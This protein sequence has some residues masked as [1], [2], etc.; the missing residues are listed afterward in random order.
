[1]LRAGAEPAAEPEP[2]R[3]EIAAG[4]VEPE[5]PP[6]CAAALRDLRLFRAR[7]ADGLDARV[8]RLLVA[9]AGEV[10]V[11]ELRLAPVALA[12]LVARIANERQADP[13]R[14]AV[15]PQDRAALAH[16]GFPVDV[17]ATL[18]PG[19]AIVIFAE[20]EIDARLGVRLAR[21]LEELR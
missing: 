11:R 21:V 7:V 6:A 1:M 16:A 15:A 8:A 4:T 14:V 17:D 12:A 18:A 13:L 2:P 9:L 10:L 20:G 3:A 19:D 5:S